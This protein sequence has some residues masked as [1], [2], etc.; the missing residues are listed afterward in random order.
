MTSNTFRFPSKSLLRY[1]ILGSIIALASSTIVHAQNPITDWD[2]IAI[3][4][5]LNCTPAMSP[6]CNT[7]GGAGIYLAYVHLAMYNAVNAINKRFQPYGPELTASKDASPE[8]AA[9]AAAYY[10]LANYLPD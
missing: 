3:N 9:V 8:A 4:T 10:T 1:S 6:G 2:F 5:T 7:A